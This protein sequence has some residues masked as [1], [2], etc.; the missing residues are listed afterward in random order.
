MVADHWFQSIEKL[1][2]AIEITSNVTKIR[3]AAF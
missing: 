1:L 2:E 3:L